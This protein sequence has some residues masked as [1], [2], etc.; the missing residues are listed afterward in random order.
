MSGV[1]CAGPSGDGGVGRD[2]RGEEV[3]SVLESRPCLAEAWRV[4]P[5]SFA[6]N[7]PRSD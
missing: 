6:M 3:D 2:R 7:D 1:R 5:E 4:K